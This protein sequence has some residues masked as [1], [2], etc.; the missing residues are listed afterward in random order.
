MKDAT[1]QASCNWEDA[2]FKLDI[3]LKICKFFVLPDKE[4]ALLGLPHTE[5]Y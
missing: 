5:L 2:K 4:A 1:K 3:K